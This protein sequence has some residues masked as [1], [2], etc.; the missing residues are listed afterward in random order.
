MTTKDL[1]RGP[2]RPPIPLGEEQKR[3]NINLDDARAE[4]AARIG[5]GN[6]SRGLRRLI[7]D[8]MRTEGVDTGTPMAP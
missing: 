4:F 1:T 6:L 2:G 3:R 8:A 7:D 5:D